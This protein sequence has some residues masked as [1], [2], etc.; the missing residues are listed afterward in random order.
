MPSRS[1]A[2]SS[3][4][5]TCILSIA[6]LL[7][8]TTIVHNP[9]RLLSGKGVIVSGKPPYLARYVGKSPM[10]TPSEVADVDHLSVR[11]DAF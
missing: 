11:V 1:M 3:T 10:Y 2:W 7:L 4:T 6:N 5:N 9:A 8:N